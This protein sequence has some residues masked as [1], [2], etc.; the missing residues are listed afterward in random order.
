LFF[1]IETNPNIV[2]AT[3]KTMRRTD[4]GR[5][6]LRPDGDA[7]YRPVALSSQRRQQQGRI[8]QQD[9]GGDG[10]DGEEYDEAYEND[11][12]AEQVEEEEDNQADDVERQRRSLSP[13]AVRLALFKGNI[14]PGILNLPY[15]FSTLGGRNNIAMA[16]FVIMVVQ[17]IYSMWLLVEC[18]RYVVMM[19]NDSN[20]DRRLSATTS[21]RTSRRQRPSIPL[22]F[23]DV[24]DYILGPMIGGRIVQIFLL[25]VQG[26]VCC[27]F[28]SLM[29]TNLRAAIGPLLLSL[30]DNEN[31]NDKENS[32]TTTTVL[33]VLVVSLYMMVAACWRD[34]SDMLCL[35][36]TAN[37]FMMTAIWTAI[38]AGLLTT[39]NITN[40]NTHGNHRDNDDQ[41]TTWPS[42]ASVI[43]FTSNLFYAFEGIGL[44]LP[45]ENE[46]G[47]SSMSSADDT[48]KPLPTFATLLLQTMTTVA[49]LFAATGLIASRTLE[50]DEDSSNSSSSSITAY[51]HETYPT[52]IWYGMV[53]LMVLLAVG[54]T[55]PLQLA[56][57]AQVVDQW[58]I[59]RG[60]H[61]R[62][63]RVD[64]RDDHYSA[65]ERTM[66]RMIIDEPPPTLTQMV[67]E[68]L[69]KTD[70]ATTTTSKDDEDIR[71]L[72][73]TTPLTIDR[74]DENKPAIDDADALAKTDHAGPSLSRH[75]TNT[76]T[77]STTTSTSTTTA[78]N[79]INNN[80][81]AAADYDD[82]NDGMTNSYT[83]DDGD[84]GD[85]DPDHDD[86]TTSYA[87]LWRRWG[88]VALFTIIVLLVDNDLSLLMGLFGAIG[89]TGLA[90]M[91]CAMHLALYYQG[92]IVVAPPSS[93]SS[94]RQRWCWT[95]CQLLIDVAILLLTLVVMV[96]GCAVS[97]QQ[98][99][100]RWW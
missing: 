22:T 64:H 19:K 96:A 70:C 68:Q 91:P 5:R 65:A 87:W 14:G 84:G 36:A 81:T 69:Q 15:A 47:S 16:V 74:W 48:E 44:V 35:N 62:H 66:R 88:L 82:E 78:T 40:T 60:R 8:Q 1:D 50:D 73:T 94:H 77:A 85:D 21:T 100:E 12:A 56:P 98:I 53:N 37:I 34:I 61:G 24:A 46:Y 57:A 59:G 18:Q 23:V 10:K 76:T 97:I 6:T 45:I 11:G 79:R 49:V 90:A 80:N 32:D 52:N 7:L 41:T 3:N 63:H 71:P 92:R 89:Q 29:A 30:S 28:L 75:T 25:I 43:F 51:L 86:S 95:L 13:W 99:V 33:A 67:A 83:D 93:S 39:M 17:G 38:I 31:D 58:M 72:T 42:F 27:V 20:S 54:L 9:D 26:G 4:S 2:A 55:V